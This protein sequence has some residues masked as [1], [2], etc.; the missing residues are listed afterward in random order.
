VSAVK[1]SAVSSGI[2]TEKQISLPVRDR[3]RQDFFH[4]RVRLGPRNKAGISFRINRCYPD[5]FIEL[6]FPDSKIWV[7]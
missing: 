4:Q 1:A 5:V 7:R 6:C 3:D 2:E